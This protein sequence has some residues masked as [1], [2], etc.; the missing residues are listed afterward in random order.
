MEH[1]VYICGWSKSNRG[2]VFW[3]T[4][5]PKVRAKGKTYDEAMDAFLE[6]IWSRGGA[7]HPVMEFVPPLPQREFDKKYSIPEIFKVWGDDGCDTDR[8]RRIPFESEEERLERE[9]WYDEFFYL[10][11]CR[12]C[13][14][15]AGPRNERP[16]T[17]TSITTRYEGAFGNVAGASF[18]VF[19]ENFLELLTQE[20][21]Q[22]IEFRSVRRT[23]KVRKQYFEL[24]GPSG[25]PEVAVAGLKFA[26]WRCQVC[27]AA[28]FGHESKESFIHDF[29]ARCDLPDPLPEVFTIGVEPNVTLCV[30]AQ[31]WAKMVGQPGTRGIVSQL[32]G[33]VPDEEVVRTPELTT[34]RE[35]EE[36]WHAERA[37][38]RG[39]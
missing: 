24:I 3:I 27:G 35:Q 1:N 13:W 4:D 6:T 23:K 22:R 39:E 38:A 17:L 26:G 37:A 33:V 8:P 12:E 36:Q 31:R 18:Y 5:K 2:F 14:R 28:C 9:S 11:C 16:L 29:V 32:I 19:S 34:R 7:Q 21:L 20:E 10:P 30:T 25:P 15:P